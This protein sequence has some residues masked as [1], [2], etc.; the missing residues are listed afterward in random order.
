MSSDPREMARIAELATTLRKDHRLREETREKTDINKSTKI[1]S[2]NRAE[3]DVF[4]LR[5]DDSNC[6][7][8]GIDKFRVMGRLRTVPASTTLYI[9]LL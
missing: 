7:V 4:G 2:E 8:P 3:A 5:L 1:Q 6:A 9:G